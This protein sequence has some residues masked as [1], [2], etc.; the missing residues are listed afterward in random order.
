M[1]QSINWQIA[2]AGGV[3]SFLSPCVL[4]MVPA[5]VGY[6]TGTS[7]EELETGGA[8]GYKR[9]VLMRSLGFILGF[10]LIF[11]ALGA[12]AGA[13]GG[14][15][16]D[17]RPLLRKVG[18]VLIFVFGLHVSGIMPIRFLYFEKRSQPGSQPG[19]FIS[20]VLMGV[21]F[22]AGWSPCVGPILVG[23]LVYIG[24]SATVTQGTI[25]LAIYSL[26][27]A[28]PFLLTGLA[29]SRFFPLFARFAPYLK[30]VSL[31][32][33][34]LLMLMGL[35]IFSNQLG[36]LNQYFDFFSNLEQGILKGL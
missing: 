18:G 26:G 23:I 5:Y 11:M 20:S 7:L 12:S 8:Q 30:Y 28:V 27:L 33:G 10:S 16:Q 1:P 24:A 22:A 25:F 13:I 34:G 21:A 3:I 15:L 31:I 14:L 17:Y 19:G 2:L 6:L 29:I 4:P 36:Q 35:L 9:L 32:S